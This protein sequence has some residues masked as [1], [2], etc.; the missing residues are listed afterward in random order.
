[1]HVSWVFILSFLFLLA[2][3][4]NESQNIP[5]PISSPTTVSNPENPAISS[6]KPNLLDCASSSIKLKKSDGTVSS[7]TDLQNAVNQADTGSYI[8]VG[9]IQINRVISIT[10]KKNLVIHTACLSSVRAINITESDSITIDGFLIEPSGLGLNAVEIFGGQAEFTISSESKVAEKSS[11]NPGTKKNE[12]AQTA[13]V[14]V[15]DSG[16]QHSI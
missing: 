12:P 6:P 4:N 9:Y 5:I 15:I 3:T 8:D 11:D 1:M 16:D 2:C 10:K 14:T 13:D 7:F